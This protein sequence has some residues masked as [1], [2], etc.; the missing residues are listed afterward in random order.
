[1]KMQLQVLCGS[2]KCVAETVANPKAND[3]VTCPR[4]NRRDRFDKVMKVVGEHVA[5]QASKAV[6]DSLAKSNRGNGFLK[7]SVNKLPNRTFCWIASEIRI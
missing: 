4:C 5:Y 2:C 7:F 1:M 3:D 6:A